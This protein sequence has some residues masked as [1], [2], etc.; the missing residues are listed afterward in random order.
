MN[1]KCFVCQTECKLVFPLSD[2]PTPPKKPHS[3]NLVFYDEPGWFNC[4]GR[5]IH[6]VESGMFFAYYVRD[7]HKLSDKRD[8]LEMVNFLDYATTVDSRIIITRIERQP[9][10][11]HTNYNNNLSP[12]LDIQLDSSNIN[13][14]SYM[15]ITV[16]KKIVDLKDKII[17]LFDEGL[18][19]KDCNCTQFL[20]PSYFGP[21]LLTIVD[22]NDPS[23]RC[24][25]CDHLKLC[26]MELNYVKKI[27]HQMKEIER[28]DEC[29]CHF[30]KKP[31]LK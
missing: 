14:L 29:S 21:C 17:R 25:G 11:F 26:C 5:Q 2:D 12:G 13:Q 8:F 19:T 20:S 31:K 24:Q 4:R 10:A 30:H 7:R 23:I 16:I 22:L 6:I 28:N 27:F 15:P 18:G 3:W 9:G 1:S